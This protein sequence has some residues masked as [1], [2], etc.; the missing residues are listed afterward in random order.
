[1]KAKIMVDWEPVSVRIITARFNSWWQQVTI[2]QCFALT[3][4]AA[5]EAKVDFYEQEQPVV[6]QVP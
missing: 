1:M 5:E 2:T 4:A 3:T 6:K